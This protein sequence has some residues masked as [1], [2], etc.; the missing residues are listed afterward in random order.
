MEPFL[1]KSFRKQFDK[2]PPKVQQQFFKRLDLFLKDPFHP[3]LNNHSVD[4]VYP[5]WRS[6]NI[7]GDYRALYELKS[8]DIFVFMKIGTHSEL[9]E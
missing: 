3:I 9:Y 7:T 2:L 4:A 5:N 6:I 1:H 8:E